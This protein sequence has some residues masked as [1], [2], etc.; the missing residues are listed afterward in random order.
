MDRK[1]RCYYGNVYNQE[2]PD[3]FFVIQGVD[4]EKVVSVK[5]PLCSDDIE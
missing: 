2:N 5:S 4:N 1:T 3:D